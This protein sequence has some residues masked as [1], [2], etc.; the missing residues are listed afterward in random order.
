[1]LT[2]AAAAAAREEGR[3]A[4]EGAVAL[5]CFSL[6]DTQALHGALR[7][8]EC[9]LHLAGP[10]EETASTVASGAV[11]ART[12][13]VDVS[14][15]WRSVQ[16]VQALGDRAAASGVMLLPAA[17]FDSVPTDALAARL[18]LRWAASTAVVVGV[19]PVRGALSRGTA[20]VLLR[21]RRAGETPLALVGGE[22]QPCSGVGPS[23]DFG[24]PHG[25]LPTAVT[26]LPD[27]ITASLLP[28]RAGEPRVSS[29]LITQAG[30]FASA[31]PHEVEPLLERFAAASAT[32]PDERVRMA[33]AAVCSGEA[34]DAAGGLLG[35]GLLRV[36]D[37]YDTTVLCVVEIASRVL[38]GSAPPGFQSPS[39]AFGDTLLDAAL[40]DRCQWTFSDR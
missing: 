22:V 16:A 35:R 34:R 6:R 27:L 31:R 5:S 24:A 36:P 13:Y 29:L 3:A 20:R 12:H 8:A 18:K 10:Y 17:G 4:A 9:V 28:S 33:A 14:G 40:G 23:L 30:W 11:L 32:G 21:A 15:E 19:L 38:S 37:P 39:S 7:R 25:A 26:A 2:D 1:M